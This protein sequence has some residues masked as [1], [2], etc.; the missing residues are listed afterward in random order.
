M[1]QIKAGVITLILASCLTGG[2]HA[3]EGG[4]QYPNGGEN[5]MAGAVPPP[6]DYFINYSGHYSGKLRDGHGNKVD[7]AKVDAW[8]N[9]FRY[10]N[11]T[12]HKILGG[13]WGWHI[14]APVVNQR[15]RLG[16]GSDTVTGLGDITVNP[17]I[18]SWHT[19]NW[20]WATG[21]DI[22]L[23]TGRYSSG[24]S[25]RSIGAN[26]WSFEPLLA[27]TYRSDDGWEASAKF[28][29]N[30]K[31]TNRNFRA[32]PG[33]ER[34]KYRSGDE[35]HMDYLI[36]KNFG[37][38]GVGVSGYYL[39]QTSNDKLNG[40]PISSKLGPWSDGRKGRVFAIGPSVT[41]STKKGMQFIAQWQHETKVK[42]RFGG[43]KFWLKFIMPL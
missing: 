17:M 5:W 36:G 38:W 4:D 11:V 22:N 24:E 30:L 14:I 43:D 41:Y 2:A 10:I 9:A 34:M 25:R 37:Q 26:Y 7:D 16:G 28:M 31:T 21:V 33:T 35:F 20:H 6:G 32:A 42:N 12:E 18:L 40:K 29:Y 1:Q 19:K 39:Q 15:I 27:V 13:N 23:P 8:F 3:K